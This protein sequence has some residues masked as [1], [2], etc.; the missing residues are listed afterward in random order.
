MIQ[1][2][3]QEM[4]FKPGKRLIV[5]FGLGVG[6]TPLAPAILILYLTR[7]W[8][9]VLS[10]II[11]L[12]FLLAGVGLRKQSTPGLTV[13]SIPYWLLVFI[14]QIIL[15]PVAWMMN[16]AFCAVAIVVGLAALASRFYLPLASIAPIVG[17]VLMTA[18]TTVDMIPASATI[19]LTIATLGFVGT[20]V[21]IWLAR[22]GAFVRLSGLLIA[23]FV[24]NMM[25]FPRGFMNYKVTFPGDLKK[26]LA[27]PGIE[28][29]YTYAD[30]KI[31]AVVPPQIMFM[32]RVPHTD[33]YILGPHDPFKKLYLLR[34]GDPPQ[35]QSLDFGGR[36]GDNCVFA[37]DDSSIFY[38]LGRDSLHRVSTNPLRITDTL[39]LGYSIMPLS[40]LKL[41]RETDQFLIGR[42]GTQYIQ[43]ID[44]QTLTVR[45]SYSN[46]D[47][48]F[49]TDAWIDP[50]GHQVLL[51]GCDLT[52]LVIVSLDM[53]TLTEKRKSHWPA[54]WISQMIIDPVGRRAY[55]GS[56]LGGFVHILD[57]DSLEH[58]GKFYLE[59]G[60]RSL[61]FDAQRRWLL[62]AGHYSGYEFVYDIDRQEIV[63]KLFLGKRVRWVCVDA[64]SGKWQATSSIGGFEIDP[65]IAFP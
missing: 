65:K 9:G 16:P 45:A 11:F 22:R 31:A 51:I 40:I 62:A 61:N 32:A 58:H 43:N 47:W 24:F 52:G 35:L 36:G 34:P 37:P 13:A 41:N 25:T 48:M 17:Y 18:L 50:V 27:Q 7:P 55:V 10:A 54:S 5:L 57:L 64:I 39:D 38:L 8:L 49:L 26:V 19:V 33:N 23:L 12:S 59:P 30:P 3:W 63:D 46:P 44:R 28:A 20:G 53:T 29:V 14:A 4:L 56:Y 6:L 42:V 1:S 15:A 2:P 21:L 60:I